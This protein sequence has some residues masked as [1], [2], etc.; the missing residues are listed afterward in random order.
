MNLNPA[1]IGSPLALLCLIAVLSN[2][3][4]A[5]RE[6]PDFTLTDLSGHS[7]HC[8]AREDARWFL[9]F[10]GDRMPHCAEKHSQAEGR[11]R[12]DSGPRRF[13]LDHQRVSGGHPPGHPQ[14]G[15]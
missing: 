2:V 5:G 4:F 12:T 13:D 14:G 10:T 8:N 7:H 15:R 6:V 3:A 1:R 11:S 9:F